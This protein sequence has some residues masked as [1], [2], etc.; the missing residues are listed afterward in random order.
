MILRTS[1]C[2][3]LR[4]HTPLL[5]S[6]KVSLKKI[7]PYKQEIK[8]QNLESWV[9]NT[10]ALIWKKKKNEQGARGGLN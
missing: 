7:L 3:L 4:I 9:R 1:H 6:V 5:N 2:Y 8:L 10:V